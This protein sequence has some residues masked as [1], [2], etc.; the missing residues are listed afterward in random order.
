MNIQQLEYIVAVDRMRHFAKAAE[1]CGV[2]QPTLSMMI[3]RLEDE[4]GVEIF[5]R[6]HSPVAVNPIGI[7]I[8]NQAKVALYNI[9]Q[10]REIALSVRDVVEGEINIGVIPTLASYII[11]KFFEQ[12]K[13]LLPN[14][15]CSVYELR[16]S[17]VIEKLKKA[18]IE[19]AIL[20]TPINEPDILELPLF[21]ERFIAYISPNYSKLYG[22]QTISTKDLDPS[23]MWLLQEGHCFRSQMLN[24]CHQNSEAMQI[25]EAG[26]IDTLIRI[27][28]TN[29][30]Y[31]LIPELHIDLLTDTQKKNIRFFSGDDEPRREISFVFRQDFVKERLINEFVNAIKTM[32]PNQMMDSRLSKFRVK[33]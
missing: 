28:D 15:R 8:I 5:D 20:S 6:K 33:L 21:Y 2:A 19:L 12:I 4:L 25:Y 30:G 26:S 13:D 7:K 14:L 18:E 23:Q 10:I 17:D 31:T 1:A 29:G 3:Q 24:I 32:I 9:K 22:N 16:T 27:V 11:P